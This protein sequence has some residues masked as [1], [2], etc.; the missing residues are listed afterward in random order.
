MA[1]VLECENTEVLLGL[2]SRDP[3][4]GDEC[5]LVATDTATPR[6]TPRVTLMSLESEITRISPLVYI[7]NQ[8]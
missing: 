3:G 5:T 8:L 1:S 7:I 2:G 6:Q 4:S